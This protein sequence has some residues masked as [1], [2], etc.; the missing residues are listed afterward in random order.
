M[1]RSYW[2]TDKFSSRWILSGLPWK[3]RKDSYNR[4]TAQ[5][6]GQSGI[7]EKRHYIRDGFQGQPRK[8][9]AKCWSRRNAGR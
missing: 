2:Y 9:G 8:N 7:Q 3:E 6:N 4:A 5:T 1:A